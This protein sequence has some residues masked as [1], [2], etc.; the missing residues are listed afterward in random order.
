[1]LKLSNQFDYSVNTKVKVINW[2]I[3]LMLKL[4]NQFDYSVNVKVK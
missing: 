3:V 4:S 1:M 2:I